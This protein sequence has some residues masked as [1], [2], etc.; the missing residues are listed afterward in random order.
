MAVLQYDDAEAEALEANYLGR[1]VTAQR[2]DTLKLL[3][4]RP[5][6]HVLDI[7]SGPGFLATE[8]AD[9]TGPT[10]RVLGIDISEAMV[11]RATDRN[12]RLWLSYSLGDATAI[13]VGDSTFDV[14]VSTQVAE[15]M[16][17]LTA[18]CA[19]IARVLRPGGRAL[20]LTTDWDSVAWYSE[21]PDRMARIMRAQM[22]SVAHSD[23]P[24]KLTPLLRGA[25]LTVEQV[26]C[27]QIIN[28]DRSPGSYSAAA[29]AF[30]TGIIRGLGTFSEKE[31]EAWA[32]EQD[33]LEARGEYFFSLGRYIFQAAKP[34]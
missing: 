21:H 10:G 14:V 27:Y 25:G 6:E 3:A 16:T 4:I 5:G 32:A 13:P 7:G 9:Q 15:Y 33:A 26:S 31:L 1:D 30:T 34:A 11:R 22:N 29:V 23:V 12:E 8:I 20:I 17:D 24:R 2:L 18:F 19:E 28:L